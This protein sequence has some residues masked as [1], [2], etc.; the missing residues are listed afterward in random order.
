MSRQP[1]ETSQHHIFQGAAND[2]LATALFE[3]LPTQKGS[4]EDIVALLTTVCSKLGKTTPLTPS[5]L[6]AI[7]DVIRETNKE[8][9]RHALHHGCIVLLSK[10]AAHFPV[11]VL[12]HVIA[13]FTFMGDSTMRMDDNYSIQV[14]F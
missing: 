10:L 9:H 13:I 7:V 6:R 8:T 14:K 4:E 3:I 2:E 5:A 11:L 12:D 1:N